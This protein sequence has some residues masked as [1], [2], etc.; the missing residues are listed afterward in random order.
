MTDVSYPHLM[1]E[2]QAS[3]VS[4]IILYS[5]DPKEI[6]E[7]SLRACCAKNIVGERQRRRIMYRIVIKNPSETK[8][9]EKI[10]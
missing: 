2:G 9:H 7:F 1:D 6:A 3:N 5:L 8:G 4:A 10:I